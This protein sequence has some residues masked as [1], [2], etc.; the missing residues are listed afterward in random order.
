[1]SEIQESAIKQALNRPL[2][3]LLAFRAGLIWAGEYALLS[4]IEDSPEIL[5]FATIFCSLGALAIL[6][7]REW[8]EQKRPGLFVH[9]IAA[10]FIIYLGFIGYAVHIVLHKQYIRSELQNIYS[11]ST[12]WTRERTQALAIHTAQIRQWEDESAN[13]IEE[14]LG[15]AARDQFLSRPT[16]SAFTINGTNT[17]LYT[18]GDC[19]ETDGG[20]YRHQLETDRANLIAVMGNRA[21]DNY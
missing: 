2:T 19:P 4:L 16:P 10:V 12:S 14:N 9:A 8:I 5:K 11:A 21:Y 1:M 6:E 13:W 15:N 3:L 20:C 7:F 18:W 17:P